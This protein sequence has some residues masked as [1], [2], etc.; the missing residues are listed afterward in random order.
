MDRQKEMSEANL[1]KLVLELVQHH[2]KV[3][4][5]WRRTVGG[6][7]LRSGSWVNFGQEGHSDIQGFM[8]DGRFMAIECKM[9]R[10]RATNAQDKFLNDVLSS[11]GVAGIARSVEDAKAIL[12]G[13][14]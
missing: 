12:D 5:A 1:L 3:K 6:G 2:P 8:K 10:E 13:S 4:R 14:A 11:G 9:P 7:R